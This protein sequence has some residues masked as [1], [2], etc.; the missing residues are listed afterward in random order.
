M[1]HENALD[2]VS[3]AQAG[4][5]TESQWLDALE[6]LRRSLSESLGSYARLGGYVIDDSG[7]CANSSC[8]AQVR[9][10]S[11]LAG[12]ASDSWEGL[13]TW[14]ANR[15]EPGFAEA[16]IFPFRSGSV[17]QPS[18]RLADL[19][20]DA[21]TDQFISYRFE[22]GRFDSY[23]WIHGD[24]PGEW[25]GV[26]APGDVYRQFLTA[27]EGERT[28]LP[29]EP[30][31]LRLQ[32]PATKSATYSKAA[33]V[34]LIHVNRN[35]ENTNLVPWSVR[36]PKSNSQHALTIPI[37]ALTTPSGVEVRLDEFSIRGG[38]VPGQYYLSVRIQN[39]FAKR[40]WAWIC[41][42]SPPI[43]ITVEDAQ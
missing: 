24:G 4:N 25:A 14:F 23:G 29:G 21:E 3:R 31:A 42:I 19:G 32:L 26:I 2:V 43:C 11:P 37:S 39:H 36:P 33:R 27:V 6:F 41:D 22:N 9:G 28:F 15:G 10:G 38:W 5:R 12:T 34:S 40:D 16:T 17:V 18:G 7:G 30:I 13:L 20:P 35:R 8:C 1:P